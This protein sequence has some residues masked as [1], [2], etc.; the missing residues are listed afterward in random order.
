MPSI[1]LFGSFIGAA[2]GAMTRSN[3]LSGLF[4]IM[5]FK[6]DEERN[7]KLIRGTII[8]NDKFLEAKSGDTINIKINDTVFN[9]YKHKQNIYACIHF[10]PTMSQPYQVKYVE[11]C[12]KSM[13]ITLGQEEYGYAI[14]TVIAGAL[15][16]TLIMPIYI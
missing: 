10:S 8:S 6:H 15:I 13:R 1:Y 5:N 3:S 9:Q 12:R 16:G 4:R 11:P 14:E 2:I 7:L